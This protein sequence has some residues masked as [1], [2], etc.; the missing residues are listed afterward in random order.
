MTEPTYPLPDVL[1]V[2]GISEAT[3]TNWIR[4]GYRQLGAISQGRGKARQLAVQDVIWL[5]IMKSC[6]DAGVVPSRAAVWAR[7]ALDTMRDRNFN[8]MHV[9]IHAKG[10][11]VS[12]DEEKL[13]F[14]P[15]SQPTITISLNVRLIVDTVRSRLVDRQDLDVTK[16]GTV[17]PAPGAA[18]SRGGRLLAII[19][20][21]KSK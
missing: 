16:S 4:R 19:P 17:T 9:H 20:E 8:I 21:S 14:G 2:L 12:L 11:F 1:E 15:T 6:A 3:A 13:P 7:I 5:A 10:E 18:G